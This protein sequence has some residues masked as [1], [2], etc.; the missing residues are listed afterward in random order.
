MP[1]LLFNKSKEQMIKIVKTTPKAA[2]E[3]LFENKKCYIGISLDN[4]VFYR[5]SLDILLGWATE[6]FDST[7][8]IIG[9]YLRRYN[10]YIFNG[11]EGADAQEK[12]LKAGDVF[13]EQASET[14][15]RYA[16][17]G[18]EITR[19]KPCIE[20]EIFVSDKKIIDNLYSSDQAFKAAVQKDAFSFIKR[21]QDNT[22][23]AGVSTEKAIE[24][25]SQYLLEEIAV[26]SSL[27][28]QGYKI[29]IY[30]GPELHCLV[31]IAKGNF[32]AIPSGLKQRINVE[33]KV[34]N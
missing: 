30:P 4:Q 16:D 24:I 21:Q 33:V 29:E 27:S 9:D 26:F 3:Q 6:K 28:E 5:N 11:L 22:L 12:S 10:E 8:I 7:L 34:Q 19:W 17:K 15:K 32:Q 14:L 18:L 13:L 31:E 23:H 2:N 1:G 20:N 25:S